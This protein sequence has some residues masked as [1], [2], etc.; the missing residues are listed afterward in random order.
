MK[1]TSAIHGNKKDRKFA[2]NISSFA[3]GTQKLSHGWNILKNWNL[4]LLECPY[5]IA[6]MFGR[7]WE[8]LLLSKLLSYQKDQAKF[9]ATEFF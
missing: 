5:G 2:L 7:L 9:V 3:L 6:C 8:K 4:L 1:Y